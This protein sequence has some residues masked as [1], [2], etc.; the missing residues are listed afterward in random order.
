MAEVSRNDAIEIARRTE[1]NLRYIKAEFDSMGDDSEVHV[2]TQLVN[3]LLGLVILPRESYFELHNDEAKLMDL[4][5]IGWPEWNIT[6]GKADT[7]EELTRHI[8][9]AAAHGC[10]IFSSGS[11]RL[12]E[13]TI[14]IE[15]S[16][17]MGKSINW[18]A[19]IKGDQLYEFCL[20]FAIHARDVID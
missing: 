6:K 14:T 17:N 11:R 10:I 18:R 16:P 19:T 1:K 8:R 13:V 2:I 7:L 4:I 3:S 5:S 15:D 20:K 12:D 9:N